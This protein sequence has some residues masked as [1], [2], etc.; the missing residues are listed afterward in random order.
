M[1]LLMQLLALGAV[2]FLIW[3][4]YKRV[5]HDKQ[6]F[7]KENIS[8]S[9]YTMGLLGIGMIGFIALCAWFLNAS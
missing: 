6:A 5:K 3:F 7:S 4:L 9:F 1:T 2:V 8:K